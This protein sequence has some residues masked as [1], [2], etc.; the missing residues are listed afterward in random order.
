MADPNESLILI[1]YFCHKCNEEIDV[2]NEDKCIRCQT[3][4][5]E[6][7]KNP[8]L[9]PFNEKISPNEEVMAEDSPTIETIVS[10]KKF[11]SIIKFL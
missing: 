1:N 9:N 5:V 7:V 3:G 8:P 10:L 11:K 6:Q 2:L 4:F